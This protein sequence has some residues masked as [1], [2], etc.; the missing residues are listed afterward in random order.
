MEKLKKL[1]HFLSPKFQKVILE[2][3]VDLKAR[4]G[5]G[6]PPHKGLYEMINANRA[7]YVDLANRFLKY[8]EV[9]HQIK[10]R[11]DEPNHDIPAWNNN[12]LPGLDIVSIY[13]I[14]SELNPKRYVEI[15]SGN[16]TIVVRKAIEDNKL[17][18]KITSIDPFPRKSI[19]HLSDTVIRKGI[20]TLEDFNFLH[21]LEENDILFLD[22]SHV[23][24][25]NS[26]VTVFFMDMLPRLKKGVIVQV[27]DIYLPYDYEP[28]MIQ[29][30]YSEQ[31]LLAA[32]MLANKEKYQAFFPNFFF[33]ED[34]ELSKILEPI[35]NHNNLQGVEKHGGCFWLKVC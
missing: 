8:K 4:Y 29:R 16:S 30:Y 1:Y 20:D 5:W 34:K 33:S 22:G 23:C 12:Y 14:I 17:H 27:H 2:Y 28:A 13:S 10:K 31:Y 24:V 21:E 19:D 15:G 6:R 11:V 3:P 18:T 32:F 26:D 7:S 25:P 35:W 9:F